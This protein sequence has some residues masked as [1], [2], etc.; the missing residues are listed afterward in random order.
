MI[1]RNSPV[2]WGVL[3][4]R[5]DS[6]EDWDFFCLTPNESSWAWSIRKWYSLRMCTAS[7]KNDSKIAYHANL[8][9]IEYIHY[10]ICTWPNTSPN[11]EI[12]DVFF[13]QWD[14]AHSCYGQLSN[15]I[16]WWGRSSFCVDPIANRGPEHLPPRWMISKWQGGASLVHL[17]WH[18][19]LHKHKERLNYHRIF[20]KC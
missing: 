20:T 8:R 10:I 16:T 5:D 3:K 14:S 15:D 17:L 4:S 6:P 7:L 19:N 12:A 13:C 2:Q 1:S 9:W 11:P 18:F